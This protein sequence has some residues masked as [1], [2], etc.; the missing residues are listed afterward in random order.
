MPVELASLVEAGAE[1]AEPHAWDAAD[2]R[3]KLHCMC[4]FGAAAAAG[5]KDLRM[6]LHLFGAVNDGGAWKDSLK[7]T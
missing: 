3:S 2:A 7:A 4:C 6:L 5:A 1:V